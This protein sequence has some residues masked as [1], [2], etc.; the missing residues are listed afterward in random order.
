MPN[1]EVLERQKVTGENVG[2]MKFK[3]AQDEAEE[4]EYYENGNLK[5]EWERDLTEF[6]ESTKKTFVEL[7]ER[8]VKE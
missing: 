3:T 6:S 1:K 7:E 8:I 2:S 5:K 4:K